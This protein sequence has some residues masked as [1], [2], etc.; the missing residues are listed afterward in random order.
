MF[1]LILTQSMTFRESNSSLGL[2]NGRVS[3]KRWALKIDMIFPKYYRS[4]YVPRGESSED[5]GGAEVGTDLTRSIT[6][7]SFITRDLRSRD[8]S[9][10]DLIGSAASLQQGQQTES[11]AEGRSVINIKHALSETFVESLTEE[12]NISSV[13]IG[14]E[15]DRNLEDGEEGPFTITFKNVSAAPADFSTRVGQEPEAEDHE[16]LGV[17]QDD[18]DVTTSEARSNSS[19]PMLDGKHWGPE[20]TVEART[21]LSEVSS[22]HQRPRPA[23]RPYP[24]E[25]RAPVASTIPETST[26]IHESC[27]EPVR[28]VPESPIP[29]PEDPDS[30]VNPY[31]YYARAALAHWHVRAQRTKEIEPVVEDDGDSNT[32]LMDTPPSDGPAV[33]ESLHEEP[34]MPDLP[35]DKPPPSESF[36]MELSCEPILIECEEIETPVSPYDSPAHSPTNT[37]TIEQPGLPDIKKQEIQANLK[38]PLNRR[39]TTEDSDNDLDDVHYQQGR[40]ETKKGVEI[41]RASAGALRR[42]KAEKASDTEEEDEFG[43][44]TSEYTYGSHS[45]GRG[46][47]R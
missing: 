41:D 12:S 11:R 40:I 42:S 20:R 36:M 22:V 5:E 21:P 45:A 15:K 44:T 24:Q 34:Q 31:Y 17:L 10:D 16:V 38:K 4:P 13:H 29:E 2:G 19:S 43:Y 28:F 7:P 35:R 32:P 33:E 18:G 46:R 39:Q 23:G 25:P 14:G 26:P 9:H 3:G 1:R 37:P 47:G 27:P 30:L 8:P 6:A